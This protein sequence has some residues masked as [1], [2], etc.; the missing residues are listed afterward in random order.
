MQRG[1]DPAVDLRALPHRDIGLHVAELV[2][3]G[4]QREEGVGIE[5]FAKKQTGRFFDASQVKTQVVPH[6]CVGNHVPAGGIGAVFVNRFEGVYRVAQAF[7]HFLAIFVQYQ[8]IGY[9]V[10]EGHTVEHHHGDGVQGIK[11]APGLIHALGDE[12]GRVTELE[13]FLVF[14]RIVPLRIR[15]GARVEPNVDQVEFAVQRLAVIGYQHDLVNVGAVQVF[16][17]SLVFAQGGIGLVDLILQF[18]NRT[19][20]FFQGTLLV[21]PNWERDAP[22]ARAGEVPVLQVFEPFAKTAFTR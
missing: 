2:D 22:V 8:T 18:L 7:G 20:A 16:G 12:V 4:V 19:D 1:E 6:L 14:K 11:P 17:H 5:Q 13:V 3:V 9:H 10:F 15:H 21:A